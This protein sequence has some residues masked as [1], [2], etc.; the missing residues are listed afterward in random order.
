MSYVIAKKPKELWKKDGYEISGVIATTFTNFD[1]SILKGYL[2]SAG[3]DYKRYFSNVFLFECNPLIKEDR[4][5][6]LKE[7]LFRPNCP[8]ATCAECIGKGT[9]PNMYFHPKLWLLRFQNNDNLNDVIWRVV[10]SSRNFSSGADSLV[11]GFVS[12]D[13]KSADFSSTSLENNVENATRNNELASFVRQLLAEKVSKKFD[14]LYN[15]ICNVSFDESIDFIWNYRQNNKSNNNIIDLCKNSS[16]IWINSPFI[17]G[18]FIS[19]ICEKKSKKIHVFA[20]SPEINYLKK[21]LDG[22]KLN[23]EI[24]YYTNEFPEWHAKQFVIKQD[25]NF[26]FII[27]SHNATENAMVN[28][29]ELS[30]VINI[31]TEEKANIISKWEE[32]FPK[33]EDII[34]KDR[35]ESGRAKMFNETST[36]KN[37]T[38]DAKIDYIGNI[39]DAEEM[40]EI[41]Q[42]SVNM[43]SSKVFGN[44]N[45]DFDVLLKLTDEEN[46][47]DKN[48][49]EIIN[50]I[51][52][53]APRLKDINVWGIYK[54]EIIKMMC[55]K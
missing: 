5:K 33:A 6:L 47:K 27:G 34:G 39:I 40:Q 15:E 50:T 13:S 18:A 36:L 42:D 16:E 38:D 9:R 2:R 10:V 8:F 25:N 24:N 43:I 19:D 51:E 30:V 55:Q 32:Y 14:G 11:D 26:L 54:D 29:A 48:I 28:N 22:K 7:R 3:F 1:N 53:D 49:N 17:N 21:E 4:G 20:P 31:T 41:L 45:Y 12:I 37:E 35:P 46:F 52:K 23:L 44:H